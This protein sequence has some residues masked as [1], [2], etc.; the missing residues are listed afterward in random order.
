MDLIIRQKR[1]D[2][3]WLTTE[4]H[5]ISGVFTPLLRA[6]TLSNLYKRGIIGAGPI[7]A[8]TSEDLARLAHEGV[9]DHKVVC[10]RNWRQLIAFPKNQ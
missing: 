3:Y 2:G 4:L 10:S 7:H 5:G 8:S 6:R 9:S 1:I